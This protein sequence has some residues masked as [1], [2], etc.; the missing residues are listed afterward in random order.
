[1]Q[2]GGEHLPPSSSRDRM[3]RAASEDRLGNSL[4]KER[5]TA[6]TTCPDHDCGAVVAAAVAK[7]LATYQEQH[8]PTPCPSPAPLPPHAARLS[9][10]P[11][12]T[13]HN[14]NYNNANTAANNNI[15]SSEMW[16]PEP[17]RVVSVRSLPIWESFELRWIFSE[18]REFKVTRVGWDESTS[19]NRIEI[20]TVVNEGKGRVHDWL[21]AK[22]PARYRE[23]TAAGMELK[24]VGGK[25]M[26]RRLHGLE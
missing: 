25:S 23:L 13:K 21:L 24:L 19:P 2:P 7:A 8:A 6:A 10:D 1:M 12:C 14:N 9:L 26:I 5:P 22:D 11:D 17:I 20:R 4:N 16:M 3:P 15:N 18:A